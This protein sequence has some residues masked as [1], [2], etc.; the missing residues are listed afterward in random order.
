MS[1][2]GAKPATKATE[3]ETSNLESLA[4]NRVEP[5][6]LLMLPY[7][8]SHRG[9]MNQ[10][11]KSLDQRPECKQSLLSPVIKEAPDTSVCFPKMAVAYHGD[12]LS[13][14]PKPCLAAS[15]KLLD[16][17]SD[18]KRKRIDS[19]M[20]TEQV[21]AKY[22]DEPRRK[23]RRIRTEPLGFGD[24]ARQQPTLNCSNDRAGLVY[25]WIQEGRWPKHYFEPDEGTTTLLQMHQLTMSFPAL[26][27]QRPDASNPP[28][29]GIDPLFLIT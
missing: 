5:K 26:L 22:T 17:G 12:S 10:L 4:D 23:R 9:P 19:P 3:P 27:V 25:H 24:A 29:L 28:R 8:G 7:R 11:R 14:P 16:L 1:H 13:P 20:Y 15:L 6:S 21:F 18:R 2:R